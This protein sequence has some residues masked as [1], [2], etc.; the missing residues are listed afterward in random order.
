[1][2]ALDDDLVPILKNKYSS[3]DVGS[4]EPKPS[5]LKKKYSTDDELEDRP[6]SI[7]K[8]TRLVGI[9]IFCSTSV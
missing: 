3:E 5:I 7:L 6:K 9:S 8:T 4:F 1:M 2:D